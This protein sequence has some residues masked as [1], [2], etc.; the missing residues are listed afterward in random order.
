LLLSPLP[1]IPESADMMLTT[2]PLTLS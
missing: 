1:A 2:Q